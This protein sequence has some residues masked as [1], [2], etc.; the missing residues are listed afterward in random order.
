TQRPGATRVGRSRG[1]HHRMS[2]QATPKAA[3]YGSTTTAPSDRRP[4]RLPSH[5]G[6][7]TRYAAQ[8]TAHAS[9]VQAA[10]TRTTPALAAATAP[11]T[12]AATAIPSAI[13][14]GFVI[15]GTVQVSDSIGD[16][17]RRTTRRLPPVGQNSSRTARTL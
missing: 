11:V 4:S 2:R 5:P 3:R 1:R 16:A 15:G 13:F 6:R 14:P 8:A 9:V 12:N 7:L 10:S 17:N